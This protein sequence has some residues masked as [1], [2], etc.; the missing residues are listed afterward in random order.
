LTHRVIVSFVDG[1]RKLDE[2]ADPSTLKMEIFGFAQDGNPD[3]THKEADESQLLA[4]SQL[5]PGS[6]PGGAGDGLGA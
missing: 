4:G 1:K 3:N 5:G 2:L 6:P